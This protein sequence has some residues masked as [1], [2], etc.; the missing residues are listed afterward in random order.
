MRKKTEAAAVKK[1]ERE[2]KEEKQA[3]IQACVLVLVA[4]VESTSN[5]ISLLVVRK[6]FEQDAKRRK[7][8]N[9]WSS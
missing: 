4:W 6:R 8:V 9:D 7:N 1:L 2:L 3:E 5:S